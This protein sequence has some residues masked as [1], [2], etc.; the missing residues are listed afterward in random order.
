MAEQRAKRKMKT[1][2]FLAIVTES[3]EHIPLD[4]EIVHKYHLKAG[5]VSPF[6]SLPIISVTLPVS[7]APPSRTTAGDG[8]PQRKRVGAGKTSRSRPRVGGNSS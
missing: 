2:E 8:S 7:A 6:S 5:L 4:D 3:G 1:R